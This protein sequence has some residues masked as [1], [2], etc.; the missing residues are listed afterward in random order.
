MRRPDRRPMR[1]LRTE[2]RLLARRRRRVARRVTLVL[3]RIGRLSRRAVKAG[4]VLGVIAGASLAAGA[5]AATF[6]GQFGYHPGRN[7]DAWASR[8]PAFVGAA[9]C[10]T[11]HATEAATWAAAPHQGVTCESCHGPLAG[12]PGAPREA[13]PQ[14]P[15]PTA[16]S[17]ESPTV[18]LLSLDERSSVGLPSS[19]TSGLC[20]TCHRAV[21]GRPS[22]FPTIDPTTHYSGPECIVCHDPHAAAA[23][24]PPAILHPLAG[25]PECTVCHSP[26]G[27]RPLPAIHPTWSGPCLT[28][29]RATQP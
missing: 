21:V 25:M 22:S 10:A 8:P 20:L 13:V 5:L 23:P 2:L 7:A 24:Q 4:I 29:H 6:Y 1:R 3:A 12:H 11:C 26:A 17:G 27:M 14:E 28:C 16:E 19:G 9:S 15:T 18:P